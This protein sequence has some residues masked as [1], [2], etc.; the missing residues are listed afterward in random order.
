M[1][2]PFPMNPATAIASVEIWWTEHRLIRFSIGIRMMSTFLSSLPATNWS[3]SKAARSA[4]VSTGATKLLKPTSHGVQQALVVQRGWAF[5][6]G[7][8]VAKVHGIAAVEAIVTDAGSL[9]AG[10]LVPTALGSME[11][12]GLT[13]T[14]LVVGMP[15]TFGSPGAPGSLGSKGERHR[16]SSSEHSPNPS[17]LG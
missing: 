10:A 8:G 9:E 15:A 5:V 12:S 6:E 4:T 17:W 16:D 14:L 7:V 13:A 3:S 2:V 1:V 11:L